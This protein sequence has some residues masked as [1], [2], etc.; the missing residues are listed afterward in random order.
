MY[1]RLPVSLHGKKKQI[2]RLLPDLEISCQSIQPLLLLTQFLSP[3]GKVGSTHGCQQK[4]LVYHE[5]KFEM[6]EGNPHHLKFFKN[7]SAFLERLFHVR[8]ITSFDAS[9]IKKGIQT[10]LTMSISLSL[11]ILQKLIDTYSTTHLIII[12]CAHIDLHSC[13]Y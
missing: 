7:L 3:L 8:K 1:N 2:I 10:T 9:L 12:S 11:E 13:T 4:N 6:G 5:I